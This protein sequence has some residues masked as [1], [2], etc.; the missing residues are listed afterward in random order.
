M[1]K[2][3]LKNICLIIFAL[4]GPITLPAGGIQKSL[5]QY[6]FFNNSKEIIITT[7]TS[8]YSFPQ[9]EAKK[10]MVLNP[11]TS[12]NILR[13]WKVNEREI[14]VRVKVASNKIFEDP[15]KITKGWIKM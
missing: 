11:G 9:Q 14:W 2:N 1:I 7:N 10:L 5:N 12:I 4:I 3:L 6:K 13:N 15:N 8:L